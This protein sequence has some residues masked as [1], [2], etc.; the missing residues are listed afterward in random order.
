MRVA[1]RGRREHFVT[2]W[3]V[4]AFFFLYLQKGTDT[5]QELPYVYHLPV[6]DSTSQTRTDESTNRPPLLVSSPRSQPARS[7]LAKPEALKSSQEE[8]TKALIIA[9]TKNED[10]SWLEETLDLTD[11]WDVYVYTT[12]DLEAHHH[13]PIN[14]GREAMAYLT[15]I[16]EHYNTP[17]TIPFAPSYPGQLDQ[18]R[19]IPDVTLFMHGHR[20][21]WHDNMFSLSSPATI[22]S[23]RLS[24]VARL[25]YMNLRCTWSPGCPDHIHPENAGQLDLNKP[26]EAGFASAWHEL[27]PPDTPVPKVLSQACCAQFA[28][29]R[30][31]ILAH[32]LSTYVAVRDWL[33]GTEMEDAISGRILEYLYQVLWTGEAVYCPEEHSCYC[34]GYGICFGGKGEFEGYVAK[35]AE[36]VWLRERVDEMLGR[37]VEVYGEATVSAAIEMVKQGVDV[38]DEESNEVKVRTYIFPLNTH[39]PN[40]TINMGQELTSYLE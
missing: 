36:R 5:P 33:L 20:T 24:R 32:P 18:A 29:S 16:I 1:L 7:P 37:E 38:R 13:T 2:L 17:T 9:R 34:D 10:I 4:L 23:L 8:Y 39:S 22:S 27:F 14:K 30:D 19:T 21:S 11:G 26:E 35:G 25:G 12:D 6:N 3:F 31:R 15:Y 28:V 40:N